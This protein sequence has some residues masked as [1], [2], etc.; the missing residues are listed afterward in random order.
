MRIVVY[1]EEAA[2]AAVGAALSVPRGLELEI[3]PSSGFSRGH[4]RK[5]AGAL[6]YFDADSLGREKAREMGRRLSSLEGFAWGIL[7]RSGGCADPAAWFF[8][9]ASDYLGPALLRNGLGDA[10]LTAAADYGALA[11]EC[12]DR[13]Q[14]AAF[15]GWSA[16]EEG[17]ETR[18]R[19]CYAALGDQRGLLERIGEKRLFK[20]REDFAAF[21]EPWAK[22]CGGLAWIRET[23][24]SLVLFPPADE[25]M[26]PVLAAFRLLLDRALIGYEVFRLEIPLTFRF[27]FHEG[28]TMW[29]PPGSTGTLVSEDVNF[30]FHLGM[31]A[32]GDGA[33]VASSDCTRFI[34]PFLGDLF[35]PAGDFEGK[36]ILASRRFR[37]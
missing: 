13:D 14:E 2:I 7:D 27:A 36:S 18:V 17:S 12:G 29:R 4:R 11:T 16:L 20:L 22:E 32:A 30:V 31:K 33:I 23:S 19:F 5:G 8:E 3:L 35:S 26:N 21:L 34:P 10:R 28:R 6:V 37:E 9:G 15:P 24:G 25:G 1:A